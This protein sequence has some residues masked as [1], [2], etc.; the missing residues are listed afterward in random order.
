MR[1]FLLICCIGCCSNSWG[2]KLLFHFN[3]HKDAKYENGD[4]ISFKVDGDRN[5]ITGTIKGFEDS[6]RIRPLPKNKNIK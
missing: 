5:K 4:F 6:L 3:K 2:Q 1:C